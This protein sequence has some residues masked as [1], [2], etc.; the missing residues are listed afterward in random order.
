MVEY[1]PEEQERLTDE[2]RQKL[3]EAY[4][5]F[6]RNIVNGERERVNVNVNGDAL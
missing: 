4:D 3:K 6:S 2:Y 5:I 1:D